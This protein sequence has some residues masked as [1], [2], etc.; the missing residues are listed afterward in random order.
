MGVALVPPIVLADELASGRLVE[1]AET[2]G[3][4]ERFWAMTFPRRFP[5]PLVRQLIDANL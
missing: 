4:T 2:T 1:H 3:L 5:N